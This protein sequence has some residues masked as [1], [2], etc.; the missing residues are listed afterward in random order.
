MTEYTRFDLGRNQRLAAAIAGC[1]LCFAAAWLIFRHPA[2]AAFIAPCGLMSP[3]LLGEHLLRRRKD[4]LRMHF[5]EM[6]HALASLLSAGKSV[7]NAFL[8]LE[9]DLAMVVADDRSD[10]V[11][12]MRVIAN[13]L[14]NGEPLEMLLTD[15]ARR[16]GLEEARNFAE[17]FSVCKRA[18]GDM[19][20]IVRSTARL[21]SEKMEAEL[22]ISV[23]MAQ[24]KFES[25]IM[26]V[27]PFAFVG[28]IGFIAPDYMA[29]LYRGAGWL[30]I[31]ACLLLF[32]LCCWWMHRIMRIE[33]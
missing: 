29:P 25:R 9:Q 10:L 2:V 22:E 33:V 26:M 6:L 7:E 8:A 16:S 20:G 3:R 24:K 5:K 14:R 31:F 32:L 13:R 23:M 19:V 27:M 21:I 11:R 1:V 28:F 15:F 17:A 18:G 12:E 30:V 4:K